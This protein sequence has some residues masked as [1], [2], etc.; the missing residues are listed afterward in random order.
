MGVSEV[1]MPVSKRTAMRPIRVRVSRP[2]LAGVAADSL[3][4]DAGCMALLGLS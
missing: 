4:S 2:F 3:V 1:T